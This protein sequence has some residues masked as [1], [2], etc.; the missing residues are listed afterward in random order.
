MGICV[1]CGT[2]FKSLAREKTCPNMKCRLLSGIE[3][4]RNGCWLYKNSSYGAYSKI[5]LNKKWYSAHRASYET[6]IGKI[7]SNKWVCHK[8]DTPKCVNPKHLFLGTPQ[9][10]SRDAIKK[11]RLV[12]GER[13]YFTKFTDLQIEE[14]RLLKKEGFSY[15]RLSRI[16]NCSFAHLLNIVKKRYRKEKT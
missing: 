4:K 2:L 7:P 14:M 15:T 1:T 8:C 12:S 13:N 11:G 10:N 6:F 16:F 3:K 9:E 5:R